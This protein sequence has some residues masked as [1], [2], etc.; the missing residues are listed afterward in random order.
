MDWE[1]QSLS[2][3]KSFA[4]HFF[5]KLC[6]TINIWWNNVVQNNLLDSLS[7]SPWYSFHNL[8]CKFM[9]TKYH[10]L[11]EK[12]LL[13]IHD[14][15]WTWGEFLLNFYCTNNLLHT[16]NSFSGW[17]VI[18]TT[19]LSKLRNSDWGKISCNSQTAHVAY[20]NLST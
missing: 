20:L 9:H 14:I 6:H 7:I 15:C 8:D 18:N 4:L 1:Q 5:D 2:N 13:K 19:I 12:Y 11:N 10:W 3:K 16:Y 17:F